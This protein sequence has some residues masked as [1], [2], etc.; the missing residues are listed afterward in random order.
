LKRPLIAAF[1]ALASVSALAQPPDPSS[2]PPAPAAQPP[3]ETPAPA[4]PPAEAPKKEAA[5]SWT[6]RV[7]LGAKAYL[8]YSY[9]L[10]E[11]RR[12]ANEFNIDRLY[13]QAEFFA[14]DKVR[15]QITLDAGDTRN[16]TGNQ[17]FFAETKN[18]YIE[19]KDLIGRGV[20]LRGGIIP[21]AWI[22]YEEDLW[23][24]RVQG[25]LPV[26][27]WGYITSA[28]L[29]LAVGGTLP[30]K[31]GSF[32]VNVSN[33]EG[34]KAIE[35]NKRKE[36]QARLSINPL[37]SMGGLAAGLFV[38]GYGS[39][40]EYDDPGLPAR[41][42]SRVIAQAGLQSVPVTLAVAYVSARDA[43]AKVKGRYTVS[44]EDIVTGQ[45]IYG[46]GVLN[47]GALAHEAEGVDLFARYDHLTPDKDVENTN[48]DLLIAGVGYRWNKNIKSLVDY[49]TV[50]YGGDV[51]G[52]DT[53]KPAEKRVKVQTEFRF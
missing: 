37:A 4:P 53:S 32:Y 35:I 46:F 6:E 49:E 3:A 39:Y 31:Y 45:G 9:E 20:Y 48:V 13:L 2:V 16:A 50:G 7:K 17:V 11:E 25:S 24:Y 29:G 5:S 43:N 12:N 19:V 26:D 38:T 21:L 27:R 47:V 8:R 14:T 42:K 18:A 34:F 33:G 36:L 1:L 15:F 44:T 52:P 10:G 51:G 22:P 30:S 41:V 23:G 28:D 40:G